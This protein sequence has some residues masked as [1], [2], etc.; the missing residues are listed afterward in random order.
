MRQCKSWHAVPTAHSAYTGMLLSQPQGMLQAYHLAYPGFVWHRTKSQSS[1]Q[2][3]AV[4]VQCVSRPPSTGPKPAPLKRRSKLAASWPRTGHS[5]LM[6]GHRPSS[7][8]IHQAAR[9]THTKSLGLIYLATDH[10]NLSPPR[11]GQI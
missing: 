7:E 5:A 3:Q 9:I 8:I 1:L 11:A 6:F 2:N 10:L 4:R